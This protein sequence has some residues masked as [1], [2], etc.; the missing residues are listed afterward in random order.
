VPSGTL[1]SDDLGRELRRRA[2]V[3]V[4]LEL[5]RSAF[6]RDAENGFASAD[7]PVSYAQDHGAAATVRH[8]DGHV[9]S[10]ADGLPVVC[11]PLLE[12]EVLP[13][14]RVGLDFVEARQQRS[15][16]CQF[17]HGVAKFSERA[18]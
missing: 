12:V 3:D 14:Q 9:D 8:A 1:S 16:F 18:R 15:D 6:G 7:N 11:R 17:A 10:Q 5:V 13:F 4:P 2:L